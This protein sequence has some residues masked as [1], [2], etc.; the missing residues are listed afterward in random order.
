MFDLS[1]QELLVFGV[2]IFFL[3][4]TGIWPVIMRGLRELRGEAPESPLPRASQS[5]MELSFRLLGLSPSATLD[6]VERA[7]RSKAKIHHPDHG[8]DLDTM[9]ALNEAYNLLRRNLTRN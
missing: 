9:K 7:F 6:E 2:I 1:L 5:D 8:G 4:A 3:S